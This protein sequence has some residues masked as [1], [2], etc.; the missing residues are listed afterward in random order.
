M[1]LA[2]DMLQQLTWKLFYMIIAFNILKVLFD[3]G[4]TVIDKIDHFNA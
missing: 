3:Y 1:I 2:S 4:F